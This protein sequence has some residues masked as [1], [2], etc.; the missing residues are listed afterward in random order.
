M[1]SRASFVLG[2]AAF[3]S[4][5]LLPRAA[6]AQ[7]GPQLLLGQAA[8]PP[9][10][11]LGGIG[12]PGL[13]GRH[14]IFIAQASTD[15]GTQTLSDFAYISVDPKLTDISI[16]WSSLT[17]GQVCVLDLYPKRS[18]F[19][20]N[21]IEVANVGAPPAGSPGHPP[22]PDL[23]NGAPTWVYIEGR[24]I[25]PP[26]GPPGFYIE[27]PMG[28]TTWME[29]WAV[30]A[31]GSPAFQAWETPLLDANRVG[32]DQGGQAPVG[33]NGAKG[34]DGAAGAAGA[35]GINLNLTIDH[36]DATGS[37]WILTDGEPGAPGQRG[38]DGQLAGGS[39]CGQGVAGP[40]NGGHGGDGGPGGN[41]GRGGDTS[42]VVV[43]IASRPG[44]LQPTA[45]SIGSPGKLR[46]VQ[47]PGFAGWA[48]SGGT[49]PSPMPAN[50]I[51]NDGRIVIFGTP[52]PG[53]PA[54]VGGTGG[55]GSNGRGGCGILTLQTVNGGPSGN[56]GKDGTPG[57]PGTG[58]HI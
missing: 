49:W 24:L 56:S 3:G 1:S 47:S 39:S 10:P 48:Y 38:G 16:H 37:L 58:I 2:S 27:T 46:W 51:G 30:A 54:G 9:F 33:A 12:Q 40:T 53:G 34:G 25:L 22:R 11:G 15:F 36:L 14:Q 19:K 42:N 44:N 13:L 20:G 5:M 21:F 50:A 52:G 57:A 31:F 8:P 6:G 7:L 32:I 55:G 18:V 17:L 35:H 29:N 28:S 45:S 43:T 23:P 26:F 41:G 4:A